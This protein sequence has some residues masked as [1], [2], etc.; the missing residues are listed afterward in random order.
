VL[1]LDLTLDQSEEGMIGADADISAG[2]ELGAAL[3][4]QDVAGNNGFAAELL[5]AETTTR[6]VATVAG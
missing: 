1:E 6:G 5:D 3:T 4:D 2:V